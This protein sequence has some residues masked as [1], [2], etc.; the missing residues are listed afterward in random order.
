MY[1][2]EVLTNTVQWNLYT[3][4]NL[5]P[6][7]Y[8]FDRGVLSS[9]VNYYTFVC[10]WDIVSVLYSGHILYLDGLLIEIELY[11]LPT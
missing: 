6:D 10:H 11:V 9:V 5:G 3:R 7:I 1:S 8:P 2:S 4:D